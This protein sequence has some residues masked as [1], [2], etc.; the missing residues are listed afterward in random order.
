VRT[1]WRWVA[2][3]AVVVLV[4]AAGTAYVL[5]SATTEPGPAQRP[6]A[7]SRTP[8]LGDLADTSMLPTPAGVA[9]VLAGALRDR[10]FGGHV[11][12]EVVDGLTGQ[13]MLDR[14]SSVA[15]PPA[16]TVKLLTA[17]AALA[18][19][20]PNETLSTGVVRD[21][22]TLYLIG[23]GDVTLGVRTPAGPPGYPAYASLADLAART[24]AALGPAG[25]TPVRLCLDTSLWQGPSSARGW[26]TGY[27]TG[28]DIAR[29]SPL[30]V[31]EGASVP[32]HRARAPIPRV[33]DPSEQA[34]E[35]FVAALGRFG[36]RVSGP[37]CRAV[38]PSSGLGIATVSSAPV[39]ALVQRM[40]TLSDNDLAE[41]LGRLVAHRA[42]RP[43]DFAGAAAAVIEQV[44]A[45][46]VD[47][48][49]VVLNDAS[50]LSRL[51]RVSA[52][53]LVQL[54]Q[55]AVDPRHPRLRAVA[56]GLPVAGLTGT[57]DDRYRHGAAAA[58][59]GVARAKTGTLAGVNTIAGYVVDAAGRLLVFAFLTDRAS[60]PDAA[61]AA[62]DVLVGRLARCG[63]S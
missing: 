61:E 46:G 47:V 45:L 28:G 53:T 18:A 15:L 16:S 11:T 35:E 22:R 32:Q 52:R 34:G 55:I 4:A 60:A 63:C 36:V 23:G 10:A 14:Q 3:G 17:T 33:D 29:P 7:V 20:G 2:L 13:T 19:L 42:G 57:L 58:A 59:A 56:E 51:D 9:R 50:G 54:V 62:L 1:R 38:A 27:F 41:S 37:V 21:G 40:L 31:D 44:K 49:G 8:V 48:T 5:T 39:S 24:A 26:S 30:E 6:P 12:G 25:T 43:A